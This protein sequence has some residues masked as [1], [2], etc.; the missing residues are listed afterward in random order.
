MCWQK[1]SNSLK[2]QTVLRNMTIFEIKLFYLLYIYLNLIARSIVAAVE[3]HT[4]RN[5]NC[6]RRVFFFFFS[7]LPLFSFFFTLFGC[8]YIVCMLILNYLLSIQIVLLSIVDCLLNRLASLFSTGSTILY[9]WLTRSERRSFVLGWEI[10]RGFC[11]INYVKSRLPYT[12]RHNP[13]NFNRLNM[14]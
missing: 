13:I 6:W 2:C 8:F 5:T 1:C 7:C 12:Y 10:H 11:G 4:Q 14:K 9:V 3:M